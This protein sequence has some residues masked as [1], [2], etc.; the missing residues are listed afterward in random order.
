MHSVVGLEEF[1]SERYERTIG[2]MVKRLYTANAFH[3][4]GQMLA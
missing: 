4:V 3:Q 2:R 1:T